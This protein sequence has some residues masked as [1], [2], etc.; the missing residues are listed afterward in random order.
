MHHSH[1]K[2]AAA[3]IT[4]FDPYCSSRWHSYH[5][6]LQFY[7]CTNGFIWW[8]K[9]HFIHRKKTVPLL[10]AIPGTGCASGKIVVETVAYGDPE[11]MALSWE[12]SGKAAI[13]IMNNPANWDPFMVPRQ[14]R[15][16]NSVLLQHVTCKWI[17]TAQQ[18]ISISM[19]AN[20]SLFLVIIILLPLLLSKAL[21]QMLIYKPMVAAN[22]S[23]M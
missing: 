10:F 4:S 8:R 3:V 19:A 2:G 22:S 9:C 6:R 23:L 12:Q 21:L 20:A 17:W 5:Y 7:R 13:V 15:P 18:V 14:V 11:K 16:L 1:F